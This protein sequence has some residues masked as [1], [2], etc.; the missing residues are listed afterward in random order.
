MDWKPY[1]DA[2]LR[3]AS[4]RAKIVEWLRI[5]DE[6]TTAAGVFDPR[7]ILS[8]PH[9]AIDYSGPLQTRV[10]SWLY[11][12]GFKRVITLGVMHGSLVPLYRIA[13]DDCA[14]HAEREAAYANLSGAFL[15]AIDRV[16]TPFGTLS[17][18]D[19]GD[20]PESAIR[21][22]HANLLKDEFSL[23]TFHAILRLAA[24]VYRLDPLPVT[25]MYVGMT[26]HPLTS[27][28]DSAERLGRWLYDHWDDETAIVTTADVVHYGAF[29]GSKSDDGAAS[30]LESSFL[31]QLETLLE[32]AFER[33]NVEDAFVMARDD[34]KA[35]HREILPPL[36]C[37][38]GKGA[39]SVVEAFSLSDYAD[40]L[41]TAPPCLVASA[42]IA[43]KRRNTE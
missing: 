27:S 38:L 30:S 2:E 1:Y 21:F 6:N 3:E 11:G 17:V 34:L 7:M 4:T 42:L 9:T 28:L 31:R 43:Y 24:D 39:P 19:L 10:A 37:L 12:H 26:R 8:F 41:D 22:D 5:A 40:I 32:L 18:T 25:P 13:A 14:P 20:A 36:V 35:D 23:D 29:Y 16:M 33:G 15:P